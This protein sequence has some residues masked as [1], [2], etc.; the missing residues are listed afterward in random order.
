[1][2]SEIVL[3]FVLFFREREG[4]EK[5][6]ERNIDRLLSVRALTRGDPTTW[7]CAPTGN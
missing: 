1:M 7:A 4:G 3:Y 6:R 2:F 5:E